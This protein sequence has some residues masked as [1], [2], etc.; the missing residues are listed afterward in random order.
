MVDQEPEKPTTDPP[1]HRGP[2]IVVA[3]EI[4]DAQGELTR[5]VVLGIL[6]ST[7]QGNGGRG[8]TPWFAVHSADLATTARLCRD[9]PGLTADLLH[10]MLAV[11]YETRIELNYILMSLSER[12]K[13]ILKVDLDPAAAEVQTVTDLWEA[14]GWYER[15]THDLFGV[16]F[17]GN[18]DLEPLLLFEGFEGHPGL[19]SFPFHDYE[20]W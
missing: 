19:K 20:D 15:E 12:H 7:V 10:C 13:F 2:P 18:E 9:S 11:D 6:G 8:D 16:T 3:E 14:A 17:A 1:A 5:D 4:L